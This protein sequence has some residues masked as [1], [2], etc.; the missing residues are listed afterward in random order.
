MAEQ[1]TI[2]LTGAGP[3]VRVELFGE[4]DIASRADLDRGMSAAI[5]R[6][7]DGGRIVVDLAHVGFVDCAAV[8]SLLRAAKEAAAHGVRLELV[9]A[10]GIVDRLLTV[11]RTR[12][13]LETISTG[14]RGSAA[15]RSTH[16]KPGA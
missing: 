6:T 8:T 11:T 2:R 14:P 15:P 12:Q 4:V 7:V 5:A 3:L 16:I 10:S 13:I 1:P 9:G